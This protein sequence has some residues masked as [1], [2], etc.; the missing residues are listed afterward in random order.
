MLQELVDFLTSLH[1]NNFYQLWFAW[2]M[3]FFFL[4][5]FVPLTILTVL[6]PFIVYLDNKSKNEKEE[7]VLNSLK[8]WLII[9]FIFYTYLTIRI[10]NSIVNASKQLEAW[11]E[12][13]QENMQTVKSWFAWFFANDVTL[14]FTLYIFTIQAIIFY[15]IF[16]DN[17]RKLMSRF[18]EKIKKGLS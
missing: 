12:I 5:S 13:I 15:L 18:L 8:I 9:Y 10:V 16:S 2:R 1:V 17:W 3:Y 6:I 14:N 11:S 4:I 7:T